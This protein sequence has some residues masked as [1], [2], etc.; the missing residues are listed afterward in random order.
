M[1]N[2][3]WRAVPLSYLIITNCYHR[4]DKYSRYAHLLCILDRRTWPIGSGTIHTQQI[5]FKEEVKPTDYI[6]LYLIVI[7]SSVA[8][9]NILYRLYY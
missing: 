4:L 5:P 2:P 1:V 8:T 9:V 7:A 3:D 6:G